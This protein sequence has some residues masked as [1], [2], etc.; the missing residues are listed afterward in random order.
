M[1]DGQQAEGAGLSTLAT[2]QDGQESKKLEPEIISPEIESVLRNSGVNPEDPK[3]RTAIE[4]SM[5]AWRGAMPLPPPTLLAEYEQIVPGFTKQLIGWTEQQSVHRKALEVQHASGDER[6]R[7]R[8]QMFGAAVAMIGLV[9]SAAVGVWGNPW[10]SA[11]IATVCVGGPIAA[12]ILARSLGDG[13]R[14][15]SPKRAGGRA[16]DELPS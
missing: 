14:A 13:I 15:A 1:G 11:I 3:V 4:I 10:A 16:A 7:D 5:M 9:L 6:R 12:V 2:N 8:A